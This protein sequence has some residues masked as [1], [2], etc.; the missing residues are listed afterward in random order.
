MG[1]FWLVF[2]RFGVTTGI[3]LRQ[4]GIL[5][6]IG[7]I[8]ILRDGRDMLRPRDLLLENIAVQ[9]VNLI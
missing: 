1:S 4:Q 5:L 2:V 8:A 6:G 7:V 3:S 9:N